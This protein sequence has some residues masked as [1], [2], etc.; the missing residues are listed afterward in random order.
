M[1]FIKKYSGFL[2]S[3]WVFGIAYFFDHIF[4]LTNGFISWI[5][6]TIIIAF[7]CI[8]VTKLFDWEGGRYH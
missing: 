8:A 1:K 3:V 6:W 5:I 7:S 4:E 2:A